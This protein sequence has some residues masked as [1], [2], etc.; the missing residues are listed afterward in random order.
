M[1]PCHLKL[2]AH[3]RTSRRG[4]VAVEAALTVPILILL[5]LACSDF[6]RVAHFQQV[7]SNA[8][9]TA[10]DFGAT[11]QFTI[12]TQAQ[13]EADVRQAALY[14]LQSLPNF[15]ESELTLDI[16]TS[17]DADGIVRIVIEVAHPFRTAVVWPALPSQVTLHDQIEIR[18]FR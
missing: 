15:D 5:G 6:G 13:W 7:V 8:A 3:R 9:R 10:A 16:S 17:T 11:R 12:F 14:E 18:Q 4:A 1:A 2:L